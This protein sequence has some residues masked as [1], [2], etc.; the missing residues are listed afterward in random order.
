MKIKNEY[1]K[2]KTGKKEFTKHN[3]FMDEY[4]KM[5]SQSQ[6]LENYRLNYSKFFNR[7][8]IK[9]DSPLQDINPSSILKS[10]DFELYIDNPSYVQTG[11]DNQVSI[12][13]TFDN[14]TS[15]YYNGELHTNKSVL[16]GHKITAISF[17]LLTFIDTNDYN[18]YFEDETFEITRKDTFTSDAICTGYEFPYHLA[19]KLKTTVYE[20]GGANYETFVFPRLYSVGVGI[21]KGKMAQE[22]VVDE[23]INV[24]IINDTTFNFVLNK[25]SNATM[26]PSAGE[27]PSLTNH[28]LTLV[29]KTS[30]YPSA[31]I[32][33]GNDIYPLRG[34]YKYI[35]MKYRL[36]YVDRGDRLIETGEEYIMNY[37]N[38]K[39]G[40]I[41]VNTK[42]E[43]NENYE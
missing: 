16:V 30:N 33:C 22:F 6:L 2:I 39:D 35:M 12:L 15:F 27:F 14:D 37:Y 17:N 29:I 41:Q 20:A 26:F 23:D 5:Y 19:P 11:T 38:E 31:N 7:V 3:F 13:Y 10:E 1:I 34:D 21:I 25:G 8:Y 43:R 24:N 9:L 32:Y 40:I 42:I 4:L 36:F 18:L 28:P